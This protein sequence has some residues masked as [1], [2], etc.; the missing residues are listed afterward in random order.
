MRRKIKW[1]ALMLFSLFLLAGFGKKSVE[2]L[3][4]KKLIDLN[5]AIGICLPGADDMTPEEGN[6]T[7][8]PEPTVQP[9]VTPRPTVTP[10]P[11]GASKPRAVIIN[12]RD[13]E[14]T[15]GS[16]AWDDMDALKER[17]AREVNSNVT[18][19]L[20]D[21]YAEAHVYRRVMAILKEL[22]EEFG[23]SYIID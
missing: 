9:T 3:S 12:V 7:Q 10:K 2:L 11:T 17:L 1:L 19:R 20:V 22:E 15:C 4:D 6:T 5:A 13:R 8:N 16:S 18:F 21:D 23:I 14:V